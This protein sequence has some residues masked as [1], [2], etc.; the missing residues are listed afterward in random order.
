MSTRQ[1]Q[2]TF[3]KSL[4][5]SGSHRFMKLF[6]KKYSYLQM[7][8]SLKREIPYLEMLSH[9]KVVPSKEK[10]CH[11]SGQDEQREPISRYCEQGTKRSRTEIMKICT[12]WTRKSLQKWK[13]YKQQPL[14]YFNSHSAPRP[15]VKKKIPVDVSASLDHLL[16]QLAMVV[17]LPPF[18]NLD[19]MLKFVRDLKGKLLFSL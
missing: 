11:T 12:R 10:D 19:L 5:G 3:I 4:G 18:I 15:I 1:N 9:D 17:A 16:D 8:A 2:K 7:K 13:L 6:H 14:P